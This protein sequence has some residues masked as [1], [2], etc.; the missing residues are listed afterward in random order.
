M[1]NGNADVEGRKPVD[2]WVGTNLGI[3]KGK[4]LAFPIGDLVLWGNV[5]I[6][7]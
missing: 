3:L 1:A 2:I 5:S 7:H 4:H 6:T